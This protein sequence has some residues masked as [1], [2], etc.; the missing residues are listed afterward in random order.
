MLTIGL[1][2]CGNIGNIIVKNHVGVEI[3]AL[4]DQMP[5]RAEEL[6]RLCG[7]RAFANI[8]EF[9][10][11]EF[12]IVVEAA[13]VSAAHQ[14]AMAALEHGKDLVVMSVG[15]FADE[16]FREDLNDLARRLGRR[17]YV[18]SGAIFGLDNLKIGQISGISKLL[19][20]ST[21]NP[22]SLNMETTE[23]TL[24]F[25]G[26]ANECIRHYPKNTNV[27]VALELAAGRPV[28]VEL[29]AD[30]AVDRNVH[31]II[32]EGDFGEATITVRNRTSPDNPATSYLAALSIVTLLKN[33]AEPMRVGT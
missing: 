9:F 18:P 29:W 2:G 24:L 5:G 27:S 25:S 13:S 28:E 23:R 26:Q 8:E 14:Y 22:R 21:K 19:L 31:E 12:D 15:A 10:N 16:G 11:Q 1:L 20:R 7:A 4:F 6:G 17:I 32:I 30:P 33:L 3:V